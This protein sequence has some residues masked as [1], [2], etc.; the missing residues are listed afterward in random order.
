MRA[1][2]A[3]GFASLGGSEKRGRVNGSN[4]ATGVEG[5][6]DVVQGDGIGEFGEGEDIVGI[7]GE[8]GADESPPKRFDGSADRSKRIDR[9]LHEGMPGGAGEADLMREAAHVR[10]LSGG[11]EIRET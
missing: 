3:F 10:E 2:L 8:E 1:G 6:G 4:G 5:D 9:V 11:R 7:F